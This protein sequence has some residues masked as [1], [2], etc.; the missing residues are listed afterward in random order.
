MATIIT[1]GLSKSM[2]QVLFSWIQYKDNKNVRVSVYTHIYM[3]KNHENLR[4]K[5]L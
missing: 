4:W 5:Q 2:E 3:T 1:A